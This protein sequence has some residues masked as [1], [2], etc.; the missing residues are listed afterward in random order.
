MAHDSADDE[1]ALRHLT[2]ALP[3]AR[4]SGDAPLAANIAA[5]S[6]HLTLQTG[7]PVGAARWA[8][9]GLGLAAHGPRTPSLTARLHTM[10]AR[11]LAACSQRPA[12]EQALEAARRELDA[13]AEAAGHPWL[14]PFDHAAFASE[15]ALVLKDLGRY[16][17]ALHHAE[18]AIA[19]RESGRARSLA[20]SRI[21]LAATHLRRADVDAALDVGHDLLTTS[22]TLGSV[23]VA[24]QLDDLRRALEAH[25]AYRPVQQYL[26]RFDDARRARMLLMADIVTPRRGTTHEA[27]A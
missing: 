13:P 17:D 20:M 7:D 16:D 2:R 21:T 1:L 22:P 5:S 4:A 18:E 15:S 14:S 19:L 11:A 12:A 26:V 25:R 6:S 9:T 8:E 23:R 27:H 24:H 3:L 10:K